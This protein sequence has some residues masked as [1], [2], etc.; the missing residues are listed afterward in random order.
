M[1][2]IDSPPHVLSQ[3]VEREHR[4]SDSV[5]QIS[6]YIRRIPNSATEASTVY[7]SVSRNCQSSIL[8][9]S[10]SCQSSIV[11]PR[12]CQ[13]SVLRVAH[14][15]SSEPWI[16]ATLNGGFSCLL[17][18]RLNSRIP[19]VCQRS[20][21]MC[22]QSLIPLVCLRHAPHSIACSSVRELRTVSEVE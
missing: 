4:R 2:P 5:V 1:V 15:S 12:H 18:R 7:A 21:R 22:V 19:L 13:P 16:L 11:L 8:S 10:D 20:A 17:Q 14:A 9:S 6:K 3:S